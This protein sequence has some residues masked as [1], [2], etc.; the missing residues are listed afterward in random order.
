[1]SGVCETTE[2]LISTFLDAGSGEG[3]ER[4]E[5]VEMLDH[6]ARCESCR[7][8][9][10]EARALDGLV[11]MTQLEPDSEPGFE[12]GADPR[13]DEVWGR[14]E[15]RTRVRRA[16]G[17]LPRWAAAAAATLVLGAVLALLPWSWFPRAST[18]RQLEVLLEGDAGQMTEDRFLD[19]TTE[20]LRAD[21]KYHFAMREVMDKVI[22]DEWEVEGSTGES[23]AEEDDETENEEEGA[24]LRT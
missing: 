22:R 8:F 21:R 18:P 1:M 3:L 6:L 9:Y 23:G 19:L 13:F 10:L 24:R 15:S 4:P 14:I 5:E 7:G 16:S 20:L 2:I 11:A 17:G 12:P